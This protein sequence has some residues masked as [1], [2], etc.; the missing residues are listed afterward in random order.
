MDPPCI[1][2][3]PL[4]VPDLRDICAEIT[5]KAHGAMP[6]LPDHGKSGKTD[7][8]LPNRAAG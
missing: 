3:W 6:V 5:A 2:G 7:N 4:P 8:H 1:S